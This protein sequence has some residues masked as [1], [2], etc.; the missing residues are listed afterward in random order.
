MC[1]Y[2]ALCFIDADVIRGDSLLVGRL[3]VRD[4]MISRTISRTMATIIGRIAR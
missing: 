2:G 4:M 3:V 1:M